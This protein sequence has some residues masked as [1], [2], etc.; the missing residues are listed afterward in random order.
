MN[1]PDDF[2]SALF[3]RMYGDDED[4]E[5]EENPFMKEIIRNVASSQRKAHIAPDNRNA[6]DSGNPVIHAACDSTSE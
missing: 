2:N 1:Y 6:A 5:Y 3:S 4:G